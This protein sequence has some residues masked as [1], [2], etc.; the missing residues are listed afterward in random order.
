M[1]KLLTLVFFFSVASLSVLHAQITEAELKAQKDKLQSQNTALKKEISNLNR[2]LQ[3]NQSESKTSLLYIQN[4][5]KKIIAQSQLV[6]NLS[7]EKRFIEDEIYLTQLEINKLSREL[8][9]LRKEYKDILVKAYKNKSVENK[10]LFVLSSKNLTQAFRRIKYLNKY[11]EYQLGKVDEILAKTA[12]IE[13]EKASREKSKKEKEALIAQQSVLK[14]ELE[15]ERKA[16]ELVIEEYKKNAGEITSMIAAKQ[17]EQRQIDAEI[18]R[19]IDEEIRL[20]KI[21]EENDRKAWN[22][23]LRVNTIAA[24]QKYLSEWPKGDYASNAHKS[25]KNLEADNKAWQTAR[26]SHTKIAYQTYLNNFPQGQFASTAR[27]EVTKFEKAERDA[28]D[29]RLK[30]ERDAIAANKPVETVEVKPVE[31]PKPVENPKPDPAPKEDFA[32]RTVNSTLSSDFA[33]NRGKL[34]WPVS[35]G[36]I[37]QGFGEGKHPVLNIIVNNDGVDIATNKGSNAKAVFDGEVTQVVS[38]P[39]GNRTVL[40]RHGSYF[41]VYNNLSFVSVKKG[42]KV[43]RGQDIGRIYTDDNGDT[44]L[45]FQ[46]R[47]GTRKENP[48]YWLGGK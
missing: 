43:T 44:I 20:A 4:L 38:I 9:E 31:K 32:D 25:I 29:A 22:D 34:P 14:D 16:K 21:R 19:I 30:A 2:D 12:Q 15:G 39:G 47:N 23:A 13:K 40:L 10:L 17:S 7:K 36:S 41:T 11:S 26:S 48:E 18:K 8:V 27:L 37:V 3:K 33:N 46:V 24:Y 35:K 1:R 28:E 6:N 5:N 42:D 45:N